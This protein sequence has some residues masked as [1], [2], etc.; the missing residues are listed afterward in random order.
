MWTPASY[1]IGDLG[2]SLVSL[3]EAGARADATLLEDLASMDIR[4]AAEATGDAYR[5]S[6]G[7]TGYVAV[8]M[9]PNRLK[10]TAAAAR[11][12][13][14]EIRRPNVAAAM[15]W[16]PQRAQIVE[17]MIGAGVPVALSGVRDQQ[18]R[19]AV[20][21]ARLRGMDKL[22]ADAAKL[23]RPPE[24]V[25]QVPVFLLGAD[26]GD[27]DKGV[28]AV[29]LTTELAL[30]SKHATRAAGVPLSPEAEQAGVKAAVDTLA[31]RAKL[32]AYEDEYQPP[33]FAG[34]VKR[35]GRDLATDDVL[36]DVWDRD[37]T[38]W[39]DDPTEIA[40]RLGWVDVPELMSQ[41]LG[42]I[43][44]FA[45]SARAKGEVQRVV[46]CGMGGSSLAPQ[47]FHRVLGGGLPLTVC[48]TTDPDFI[49]SLTA[50]LDFDK[51]LFVI[52]SKSGTTV[53]TRS[54]M[55]YFWSKCPRPDRF[56]AITDPG[57]E[58]A[59]TA[60]ERGFLRCFE[61]PPDIGGRFSALSYFGLVPAAIAAVDITGVLDGARREML[62][63][64]PGVAAPDAI[65]VRLAAAFG[66]AK[67]HENRDKLTFAL[68]ASL[69]AFGP[70]CE[71]LVA[72]STG[73]EGT[74]L[75][76]VVGERLGAPDVYGPDRI[77]A[78]YTLAGEERAVQLDLLKDTHP[79]VHVTTPSARAVGA[80]MYRWE[81]AIA[82]VGYLLDINPFDQPDVEAAKQ[83]TREVLS[84]SVPR[85]DPGSASEVLA[86]I[87][88]PQYVAIQAFITP[89]GDNEKRLNAVRD[90]L[91]DTFKV[92]VTVGFGPRFLHS[93]GQFHKGGPNTGVFL[94]VT[95]SH[96]TDVEIPGMGSTFGKLID[97]QADGDLQ[98]LRDKGRAAARV[99]LEQ[100]E[101]LGR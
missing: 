13:V 14:R 55:E 59:K 84:G 26:A 100:L 44:E 68:P 71:Q 4:A 80:E 36:A 87:E 96:D 74:G 51:T 8:W 88:P 49:A 89:S 17:Q 21:A 53:E 46:L 56:V 52:A 54:H 37:Y 19:E 95:G 39:K 50:S 76:P 97:A 43:T 2:P 30:F 66:G 11:D 62:R 25:P 92:A 86:S 77:F 48:D 38:A 42:D 69:E 91:R 22:R 90:R 73:K 45:R 82:V 79:I 70:W 40:D 5:T 47:T 93:T 63:N 29:T 18:N 41:Q 23:E 3:V 60:S 98:A 12:L 58:L 72:E 32:P 75:L 24:N 78:A 99:S 6:E 31:A 83:L 28:F 65:A 34:A 94:Q 15:A 57:T 61:N 85:P 16:A 35:E 101:S 81:M 9:D 27:E 1:E 67:L 33:N 10:D 64:G 7:R 20:T